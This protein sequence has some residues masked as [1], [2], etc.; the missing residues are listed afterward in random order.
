MALGTV[1][2]HYHLKKRK[3]LKGFKVAMD[4]IVLTLH[5]GG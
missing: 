2:E 5:K 3:P 1:F 4:P